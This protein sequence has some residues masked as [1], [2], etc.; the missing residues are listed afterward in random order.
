MK[1]IIK[2]QSEI[3]RAGSIFLIKCTMEIKLNYE[4]LEKLTGLKVQ[5]FLFLDI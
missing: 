5:K 2:N 3:I 1:I 4:E